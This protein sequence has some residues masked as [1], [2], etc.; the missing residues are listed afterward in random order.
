MIDIWKYQ[1]WAQPLV[2]VGMNAITIYLAVNLIDFGQIARRLV[3][4]DLN[5][6]CGVY[7]ELVVAVTSLII[8]LW[9][10]H[11]LYRR[12]IFLRL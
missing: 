7:G 12:K 11:F 9:F 2:W 5:R 6:Y 8:E 3:G 10:L 1:K 4:G